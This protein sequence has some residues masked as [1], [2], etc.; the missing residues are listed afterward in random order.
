MKISL[1]G[2]LR[3][4]ATGEKGPA[5]ELE[6]GTY[7][8]SDLRPVHKAMGDEGFAAG[9]DSSYGRSSAKECRS[10]VEARSLV[11]FRSCLRQPL[12][13]FFSCR[14]PPEQCL[15]RNLHN[16]HCCCGSKP[17]Q[18]KFTRPN[19]AIHVGTVLGPELGALLVGSRDAVTLLALN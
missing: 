7:T 2:L 14:L 5:T 9:N 11:L 6:P 18:R 19:G 1:Q 3:R 13:S 16:S 15:Q 8:L 4:E 17:Y 10:R 12:Y